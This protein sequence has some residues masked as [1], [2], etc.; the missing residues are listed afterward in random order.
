MKKKIMRNTDKINE[1]EK[2]FEDRTGLDFQT[3]YKNYSFFN[4]FLIILYF[5]ISSV[6]RYV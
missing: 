1:L 5:F 6:N 4:S 3:F 2:Q